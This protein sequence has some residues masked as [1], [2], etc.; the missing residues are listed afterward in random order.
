MELEASSSF[1]YDL[2]YH[3]NLQ[4]FIYSLLRGTDYEVLHDKGGCRFFSFSNII[5][6]TPMVKK[7]SER[8]LVI[9]SP[10]DY[11]IETLSK[12]LYRLVDKD[13][14]IGPMTFTVKGNKSFRAR[15]PDDGFSEFSL[16]SGTP[17]VVRIPRYRYEEYGIKPKKDYEYAYWRKE[18]TPKVFIKQLEE[19][20]AKK[21]SGYA[22][23]ETDQVPTLEKL[24]FKKQVAIPLRMKSKEGTVIGTLWEFYL[25]PLNGHKRDMLQFGLDA[26]FGEMNSL[27][28]GFMNLH[29]QR[30]SY[31]KNG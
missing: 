12:R 2:C 6:P 28:F 16:A 31:D 24:R 30:R 22:G 1:P 27:G 20:L 23:L 5:P 17:I 21:Y 9:A 8:N 4:G 19:N 29:E 18:Y 3:H 26:G 13:V 11:F 15:L 25:Q 10:D 14:K 7:E